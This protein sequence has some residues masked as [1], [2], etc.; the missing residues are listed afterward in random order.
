MAVSTQI[1]R[2]CRPT[3]PLSVRPLG[4]ERER[5]GERGSLSCGIQNAELMP[6]PRL[7]FPLRCHCVP[8]P[9]PGTPDSAA[10]LGHCSS[11]T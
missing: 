1:P 8:M 10:P 5:E 9:L 3:G 7:L 6:E 2:S 4:L 11:C